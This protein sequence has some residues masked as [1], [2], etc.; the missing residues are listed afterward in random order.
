MPLN[1]IELG[2]VSPAKSP[3]AMM[4]KVFIAGRD[5]FSSDLLANALGRDLGCNAVSIPPSSF[6]QALGTGTGTLAIISADLNSVPGAGFDLAQS[7]SFAH[8]EVAIILLLNDPSH[9]AVIRAF[10]S[11][12]SGVF[13]QQE[14]MSELLHCIDHVRK[15]AIWAGKE[16]TATLL[17]TFK[18]IPAPDALTEINSASLTARELQVVQVAATGKTNKAIAKDLRLSEHTVKNY[19]FR[20]FEKLGV[21]SR[22]ELLFY[23]AIRGHSFGP[24]KEVQGEL[25][26]HKPGDEITEETA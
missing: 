11:G 20:A 10:R 1:A 13:C 9:Q 12:A 3:Q 16:A 25:M 17:E 15:G 19:L 26:A 2:K 23:L 14:P 21:S 7:V 24:L 4:G 6:L 22:V 5:P 8:P 18:S